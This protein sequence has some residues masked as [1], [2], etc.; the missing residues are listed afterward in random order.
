MKFSLYSLLLIIHICFRLSIEGIEE[1]VRGLKKDI[2]DLKTKLK[3]APEIIVES[4][5]GKLCEFVSLYV[6]ND[7]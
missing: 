3:N 5:K 4:F 2:I 7:M 1:E 6:E